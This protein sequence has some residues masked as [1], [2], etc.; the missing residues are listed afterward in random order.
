MNAVIYG[1]HALV[2]V[3]NRLPAYR[4][5]G[6]WSPSPGGLVS[7][8]APMVRESH[9]AW[10]GWGGTSEEEFEPFE[11]DGMSLVPVALGA[12][13]HERYYEGFSNATLWPLYHDL[14]V[15]PQFHRSWWQTY[16]S[17]NARF[18]QA[19]VDSAAPG[20]T[21]W[22]H[23]F[24]LQLVPE[25]IRAQRP[26]VRIGFFNHIPFPSETIF[27]QLPWR[28]SILRGLLGADV[29]GFQLASDVKNFRSAVSRYLD[30]DSGRLSNTVH[31][32]PISIDTAAI[33]EVAEA[34][35][36]QE[37]ARQMRVELGDPRTLIVGID[38]LDYTKGILHRLRAY[39][40]L[41]EDGVL[42]P[43]DTTFVQVAE[44]SREGVESYQDLRDDV[45][46]LVG[47]I[48]GSFGALDGAAVHYFHHSY[49]FESTVALYLAADVLLVTSLRDG[50]NLVAKEYV[51][52]RHNNG[53]L[54]LSEFAGAAA[55]LHDALLVN[56]HD[57]AG[58]KDAIRL[59]VEM[60]AAEAGK[61]MASMADVV[62]RH[63][64]HRWARTFLADL[65]PTAPTRE[66]RTSESSNESSSAG[67]TK[68]I[69]YVHTAE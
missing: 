57:I 29:I 19:A 7:A 12:E 36:T 38:R 21:V 41:L 65:Q 54:V 45:E 31:A 6:S 3:A 16:R 60:P 48:N 13:E 17:T 25:M 59:G 5:E 33:H 55:E 66:L 58:L 56:P 63:D 26:D 47:N 22:I 10:I 24:H 62:E 4:S 30:I 20:A 32:Y 46:Q 67:H 37:L 34:E 35:E 69:Q 23:D 44:P 27:A 2:V 1:N 40:E 28:D 61:R 53:T 68:R 50:M 39:Q 43:Q 52:A 11:F 64:I 49:S 42:D 15:P 14:V 9:G 18:A 8:V 51:A